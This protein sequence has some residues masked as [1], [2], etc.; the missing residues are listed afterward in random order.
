M[1]SQDSKVAVLE[2]KLSMYEELSREMLS[3]LETAVQKISEGNNRIANILAKHDERIDQSIKTDET[4]VKMIEEVKEQNSREHRSVIERI[5]KV[6]NDVIE[7]SKFR[8]QTI[9]ISGVAILIIGFIVPFI[10]NPHTT[11]Y[12]GG[13]P[14]TQ[15]R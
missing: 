7:L 12:N 15:I 14:T 8:W 2:S 1:F 3:K 6:E 10:D 9:A 4:I 13:S 11:Q 5:E